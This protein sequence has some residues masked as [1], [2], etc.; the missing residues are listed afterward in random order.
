M[1]LMVSI[2]YFYNLN[3]KLREMETWDF[4]FGIFFSICWPLTF[5]YLILLGA[6]KFVVFI[7]KAIIKGIKDYAINRN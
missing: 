5:I 7:V 3:F 4:F 2:V 1:V 6:V